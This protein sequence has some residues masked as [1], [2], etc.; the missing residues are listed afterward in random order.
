MTR[1]DLEARYDAL[2]ESREA[3]LVQVAQ[4]NGAIGEVERLL[5]LLDEEDGDGDTEPVE[6]I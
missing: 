3:V 4:H 5:N 2:I 6:Q 1:E